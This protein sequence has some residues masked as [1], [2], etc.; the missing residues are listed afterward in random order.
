VITQKTAF[1]IDGLNLFYGALKGGGNKWL[2][3]ESLAHQLVPRDEIARIRY[4]TALVN[5]RPDDPRR[6]VRQ[7]TYLRALATLPTVS[8]HRGRF[9]RRIQTRVLADEHIHHRQ[10]F[11][12]PFRPGS[13]F[14]LMWRD[15][16]RRRTDGCTRVQVVIE[17]EK[18]SDVNLGAYLVSDAAR[19]RF[20]K[21]I[22][23]S[24]DSDLTDAITL[25]RLFRDD[26]GIVN[27]HD[28]PTSR[29]L[30]SAAKFEI[31][32]RPSSLRSLQLPEVVKDARGREIHRPR[33][34]R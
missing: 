30:G 20:E 2:N 23:I 9:T 6:P 14:S 27:P 4:F 8:I 13:I 10:L 34:W 17:E 15:K 16:V 19:G 11:E 29:H 31:P 5:A 32:F 3:L 12:P 26:I 28:K 1:Y 22:V 21:A 18:G 24:N 33:E 7:S 25:A